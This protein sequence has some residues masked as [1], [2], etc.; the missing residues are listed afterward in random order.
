MLKEARLFLATLVV[1]ALVGTAAEAQDG[2]FERIV[3]FGDSQTDSGNAFLLT[4]EVAVR[5]FEK[6]PDAPYL[7]GGLRLTNGPIWLEVVARRFD[8]RRSGR[9]ALLLP[10]INTN[11][12]VGASRA[13]MAP[14]TDLS[15]QLAAFFATFGDA[16][17]DWLYAFWIGSNDAR[18]ALAALTDDDPDTESGMI[19]GE[20]VAATADA[21]TQLWLAGARDFLILNIGDIGTTPALREIP[22]ASAIGRGLSIAYNQALDDALD[23]LE[24]DLPGLRIIRFDVFGLLN[25]AIE[26][27]NA[28]G[29]TNVTDSCITP[30]VIF[31]AICPRPRRYLYWDFVHITAAAHRILGRRVTNTL[32][33]AFE[34]TP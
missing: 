31:G 27:P 15:L 24:A 8:M 10:G 17:S 11:Y 26:R 21:I 14:P 9:P 3:G 25:D 6:I 18:D 23:A 22:G 33:R 20:A 12:A 4:G 1:A 34:T 5:P 7:I 30:D 13:R 32:A 16:P 28:Y 29:F 2:G 19:I